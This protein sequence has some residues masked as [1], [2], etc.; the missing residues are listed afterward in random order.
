M[1][2][3]FTCSYTKLEQVGFQMSNFYKHF[4]KDIVN[5]LYPMSRKQVGKSSWRNVHQ[6]IE[7]YEKKTGKYGPCLNHH[8]IAYLVLSF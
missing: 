5:I 2:L 6:E 1:S 8:Y 3:G 7:G 4:V